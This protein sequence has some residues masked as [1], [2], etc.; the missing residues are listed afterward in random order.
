MVAKRSSANSNSGRQ[1]SDAYPK[2]HKSLCPPHSRV[3]VS[4]ICAGL[5]GLSAVAVQ[6]LGGVGREAFTD[7]LIQCAEFF[8]RNE[9]MFSRDDDGQ[10]VLVLTIVFGLVALVIGLVIGLGIQRSNQ[11]RAPL[12]A[13]SAQATVFKAA[14]AIREAAS[15]SPMNVASAAQ[16]ASDAAGVKI[17]SGVVKFYFAS[18]KADL[19]AGAGD[20]LLGVIQEAKAG[21]KLVI[22]GFHDVTGDAGKNAELARLRALAVRDT[23]KAA[24]VTE[25]QIEL[26]KPEQITASGSHAEARRVE[27]N[28]QQHG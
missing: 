18:G 4:S 9:A 3:T 17:E 12:D 24:G 19:A 10:Q 16:A 8:K 15:A 25:Q 14:A 13:A 7:P 27:V 2:I 5:R 21:R 22:S 26:K 11:G 28:L 6:A 1:I 23:L 20:A